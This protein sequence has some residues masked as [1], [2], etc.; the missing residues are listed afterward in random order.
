MMDRT[1]VAGEK[2]LQEKDYIKPHEHSM[3]V[4]E[5]VRSKKEADVDL[6]ADISKEVRNEFPDASVETLNAIV[7]RRIYEAGLRAA[8]PEDKELTLK[9]NMSKTLKTVKERVTS[10]N[11]K[12]EEQRFESKDGKKKMAWSCCQNKDEASEGCVVKYV[13]KQ[14]WILS[15]C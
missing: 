4:Q 2:L 10:H 3:M 6:R 5:S 12:F 9:P 11:G 13:D 1:K 14:K 15:S 7:T 8:I